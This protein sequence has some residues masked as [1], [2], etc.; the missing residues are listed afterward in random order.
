MKQSSKSRKTKRAI[1]LTSIGVALYVASPSI[2]DTIE[3]RPLF[4]AKEKLSLTI[5]APLSVLFKEHRDTGEYVQ[6]QLTVH[7][8]DGTTQI[9]PMKLK[10][11]GKSRR[12]PSVCKFPPLRV[13]FPKDATEGTIFEGQDKLKLVTHCQSSKPRYD[14]Y[15]LQEQTIYDTYNVL[16]DVSFKTRLSQIEYVDTGNKYSVSGKHGFFIEDIDHVAE[17]LGL[18]RLKS[19]KITI[20]DIDPTTGALFGLFQYFVGN[21]DWAFLGGPEGDDCCHNSK[22]LNNASGTALHVPYDFDHAGVVDSDYAT[23]PEGLPLNST[24]QR[25]YRGLCAHND[26]IPEAIALF[27]EQRETIYAIVSDSADLSKSRK[28]RTS[29]YYDKFYATIND[30]AKLDKSIYK[31]CRG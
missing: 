21:L 19:E 30:A 27:N 9:L 24:R 20:P 29:S 5:E 1:I 15:Y 16:S 12:N 18:S 2:A 31:K 23:V 8:S 26:Q 7:L 17:R 6:G 25:L 28:K 10:T 4:G 14:L 13:N 22:L 11:R 3:N